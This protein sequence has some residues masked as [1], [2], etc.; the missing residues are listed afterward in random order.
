MSQ[1][2]HL[3]YF[4]RLVRQD[5]EAGDVTQQHADSIRDKLRAM[6]DDELQWL[7]SRWD[8]HKRQQILNN[9]GS[10]RQ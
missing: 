9:A 10:I 1:L 8:D 5:E 3:G 2:P 6:T 4:L 7:K